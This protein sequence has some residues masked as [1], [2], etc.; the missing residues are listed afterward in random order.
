M[1]IAA[2]F[3]SADGV[4]LGAD[5]TT[6]IYLR[7][8]RQYQNA[9]NLYELRSPESS[10]GVVC[11]GLAGLGGEPSYRG[12]LSALSGAL[13]RDPP[14]SVEEVAER[15]CDTFWRRYKEQ[16]DELIQRCQTLDAKTR[17]SPDEAEEYLGV[18]HR[19]SGGFC[20]G[21]HSGGVGAP[22]A[23]EVTYSPL[24]EQRPKPEEIPA[25]TFRFWGCS[26]YLGRFIHGID[27]QLF[28]DILNSGNWTGTKD[29]LVELV[30][31]SA[32]VP[33][34]PSPIKEG[35]EVVYFSLLLTIKSLKF[36]GLGPL[37]GGP[38]E[39]ALVTGDE[40]FRWLCHD[41]L[42][43]IPGNFGQ[44][45]ASRVSEDSRIPDVTIIG[46]LSM[47]QDE[48]NV[49][50]VVGQVNIKSKPTKDLVIY[51]NPHIGAFEARS[52]RPKTENFGE[53]VWRSSLHRDELLPYASS[54]V[55]HESLLY[56]LTDRPN[57]VHRIA[58]STGHRQVCRV[59][60]DGSV[61]HEIPGDVL[62]NTPP[63]VFDL[64]KKTTSKTEI[65]K[66]LAV[67]T[68]EG[69]YIFDLFSL[70][71]SHQPILSTMI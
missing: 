17:R 54:P 10:L 43:N 42:E 53:V 20:I 37:C 2:C 13:T 25:N 51:Y 16:F 34:G 64:P 41:G 63:L 3:V 68:T 7:A 66:A 21:G 59:K 33:P 26:N 45:H 58:L 23:F 38:I 11:W 55:V 47:S 8:P 44:Y 40:P 71:Q 65:N 32:M 46:E 62:P 57:Y 48:I 36:C 50:D 39:L 14:A 49:H 9:Q 27:S 52:I 70:S 60:L 1:T 69:I 35:I 6:T 12:M 22:K 5:S 18:C 56:L 31:R 4:V 19:L 15:W 61:M 28:T 24:L 29:E 30:M 67:L